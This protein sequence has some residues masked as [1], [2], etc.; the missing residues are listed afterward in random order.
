MG[1]AEEQPISNRLS[2]LYSKSDGDGILLSLFYWYCF[3]AKKTFFFVSF[4]L[5]I[6]IIKTYK[7]NLLSVDKAT[8]PFFSNVRKNATALLSR[9]CCRE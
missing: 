4:L 8:N 6:K 7:N 9:Q 3:M 5:S 1:S 2:A